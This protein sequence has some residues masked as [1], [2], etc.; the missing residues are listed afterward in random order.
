MA[1]ATRCAGDE[2][3]VILERYRQVS[4]C[5]EFERKLDRLGRRNRQ[6]RQM[7][8]TPLIQDP[9]PLTRKPALK[10]HVSTEMLGVS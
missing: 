6:R 2:D 1:D 9:E 5:S 4:S 3:R 10:V 8:V 7:N